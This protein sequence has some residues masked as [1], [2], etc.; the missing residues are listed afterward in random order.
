MKHSS[1][2]SLQL[3]RMLYKLTYSDP[4]LTLYKYMTFV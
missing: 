2:S 4:A 1:L 3:V